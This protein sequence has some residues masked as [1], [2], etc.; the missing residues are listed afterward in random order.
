V[1]FPFGYGLSYSEFNFSDL[2]SSQ[3]ELRHGVSLKLKFRLANSG[4][5]DG[6]EVVQVYISSP[7]SKLFRPVKELKAFKKVSLEAGESKEVEIELKYEDFAIWNVESHSWEVE[8]GNY[9]ILVGNSSVHL[10]LKAE[11]FLHGFEA[12]STKNLTPQYFNLA[13]TKNNFNL[14]EF[15]KLP[16]S[17]SVQVQKP[18]PGSFDLNA[19][20]SDMEPYWIGRQ[21]IKIAKKQA[22]NMVEDSND[23]SGNANRTMEASLMD[24]PLRSFVMFGVPTGVT[25]G[26]VD[27]L[28]NRFFKGFWLIF[29]TTVLKK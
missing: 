7:E 16:G 25:L 2:H 27:L 5:F 4:N 22:G 20:L 21:I 15:E 12:T 10:P 28:N 23:S 14:E 24:W 6:K 8:N 26:I 17:R 19:S 1:R 29:K 13:Q 11:V 18:K 9:E 3:K